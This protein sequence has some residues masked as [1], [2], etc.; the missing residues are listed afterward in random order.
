MNAF[1]ISDNQL[2]QQSDIRCKKL[3]PETGPLHT[4]FILQVILSNSLVLFCYAKTNAMISLNQ[5]SVSFEHDFPTEVV[6]M[7]KKTVLACIAAVTSQ[8]QV[9]EAKGQVIV[10]IDAHNYIV[11]PFKYIFSTEGK[12][13]QYNM[14]LDDASVNTVLI[15]ET[16]QLHLAAGE[17]NSALVGRLTFSNPEY[18]HQTDTYNRIPSNFA[19]TFNHDS[20]FHYLQNI[21]QLGQNP[22]YASY[23]LFT[24][25]LVCKEMVNKLLYWQIKQDCCI[26]QIEQLTK[27]TADNCI[28]PILQS[29][30]NSMD[31][32]IRTKKQTMN[33]VGSDLAI[34]WICY[35]LGGAIQPDG[36]VLLPVQLAFANLTIHFVHE[37][38]QDLW[39]EGADLILYIVVGDSNVIEQVRY[40]FLFNICTRLT[41]NKHQ[42]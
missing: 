31:Q 13:L 37:L 20:I 30:R 39:V 42:C 23:M 34:G 21:A 8:M 15:K 41:L 36:C 38:N 33:I 29:V 35:V 12:E 10:S 3:Y 26:S 2:K 27:T 18:A 7:E 11:I 17:G 16:S 28:V 5:I 1:L 22:S 40:W 9:L 24:K 4:S 6:N 25:A 32:M 14:D 19:A